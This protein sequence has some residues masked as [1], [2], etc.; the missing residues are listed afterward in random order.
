MFL[1]EWVENWY[2]HVF[3]AGRPFTKYIWI[4]RCWHF[5]WLAPG[6]MKTQNNSSAR[7]NLYNWGNRA[8]GHKFSRFK[9]HKKKPQTNLKRQ[10]MLYLFFLLDN[11][12]FPSSY[13]PNYLNSWKLKCVIFWWVSGINGADWVTKDQDQKNYT[14]RVHTFHFFHCF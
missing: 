3:P 7:L 1:A 5:L 11:W 13:L 4:D 9:R 8:V 2:S 12:C 14:T 10:N 6:K